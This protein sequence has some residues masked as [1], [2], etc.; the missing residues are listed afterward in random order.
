MRELMTVALLD[1][2]L[3]SS[4]S[5]AKPELEAVFGDGVSPEVADA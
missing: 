4:A 2:G 1:A 5:A 3:V